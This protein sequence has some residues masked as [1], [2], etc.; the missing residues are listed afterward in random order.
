[1]LYPATTVLADGKQFHEM[2][3]E[4]PADLSQCAFLMSQDG[5]VLRNEVT[6]DMQYA[7]W[8]YPA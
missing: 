1:M 3:D 2:I 7:G 4:L 5:E 8:P 6:V